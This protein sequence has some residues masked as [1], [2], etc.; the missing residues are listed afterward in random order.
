MSGC[1]RIGVAQVMT[2]PACAPFVVIFCRKTSGAVVLGIAAMRA[3]KLQNV[4]V[5]SDTA[6]K[7]GRYGF[8]L[9]KVSY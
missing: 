9:V 5:K 8:M 3:S 2:H 4:S 7:G 6:N 1:K